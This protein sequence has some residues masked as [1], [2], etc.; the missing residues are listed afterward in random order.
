MEIAKKFAARE[1]RPD[2]IGRASE[3]QAESLATKSRAGYFSIGAYPG[4]IPELDGFRGIA[5]LLV[6]LRH[7][8][9]PI[10]E[11]HGILFVVGS[12]DIAVP[13]LNGWMGVDLF[14]VLSG[15]LITHHLLTRWPDQF[16][17]AFALRYWTKRVLRTFPAYYFCVLLVAFGALPFYQ[18][19]INNLGDEI[20]K[21]LLF[22]QDYTGTALVPAFWSLGVEE[23]FY[24][25]CPVALLWLKR[26]PQHRQFGILVALAAV[27]LLLRLLTLYANQNFIFSYPDFFWIVRAPTHVA[28]D[29]LWIGVICALIYRWRPGSFAANPRLMKMLFIFGL[30]LF[31]L[32]F[33]SFAWLDA[34]HFWA[35]TVVLALAPIAFASMM[36]ATVFS[37]TPVNN[38]LKSRWLRFLAATSYSIYLTHLM[39]VPPAL[40][41]AHS[42]FAYNDQP[43]ILQFLI[44]L[45]VLLLFSVMSGLVLHLLVEKPFLIIKERIQL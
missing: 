10:Y 3:S 14:F 5:I 35:S 21:H 8:A 7:A 22:L 15:F 32:I 19:E 42:L 44:F 9:R 16:N 30:G 33:F 39:V 34:E 25:V 26:Y 38:F 18:P 45:P 13:L 12:W 20:L 6:L 11:E 28:L 40:D 17:K 36:L 4:A 37:V 29:G 24:I 1:T 41:L 43:P 2:L 27:P 23:K 31:V